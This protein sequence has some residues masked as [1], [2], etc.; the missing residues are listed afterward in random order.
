MI[1]SNTKEFLNRS[2]W[3]ID[4]TLTGTTTQGRNETGSNGNEGVPHTPP[5]SRTGASPSDTV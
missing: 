1:P 3:Y 2:I 5:I 4:E